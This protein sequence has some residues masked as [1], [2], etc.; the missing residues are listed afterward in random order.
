MLRCPFKV[1][2]KLWHLD[3]YTAEKDVEHLVGLFKYWMQNFLHLDVLPWFIYFSGSSEKLPSL[4]GIQ[5][6]V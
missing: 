1:K 5:A 4:S 3:P 6:A 2:D